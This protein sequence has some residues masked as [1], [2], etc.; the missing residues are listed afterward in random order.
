MT[1]FSEAEEQ[2]IS[3]EKMSTD[4]LQ[5]AEPIIQVF[6]EENVALLYSKQWQ[7]KY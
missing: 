2:P 4:L 6:G 1:E 3:A 5:A 7:A